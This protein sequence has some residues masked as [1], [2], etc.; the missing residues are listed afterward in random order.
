MPIRKR[1]QFLLH[2]GF[3]E[4]AWHTTL[5]NSVSRQ[6]SKDNYPS[7]SILVHNSILNGMLMQRVWT[8]RNV[9]LNSFKERIREFFENNDFEISVNESGD[10]YRLVAGGSLKYCINGQVSVTIAGTPQD[11]SI[12]LEQEKESKRRRY[13]LPMTL[14]V[15]LGG[16]L[17]LRDEFKSDEAFL[18]LKKDLWVLADRT[19]ID[20]T[21]SADAGDPH[22]SESEKTTETEN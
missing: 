18:K 8:N 13:S 6:K 5:H 19:A 1:H 10:T 22:V 7:P 16:G 2:E 14:T 3:L 9:D 4:P 12:T 15:F 21:G 20:L 17:L 11:F